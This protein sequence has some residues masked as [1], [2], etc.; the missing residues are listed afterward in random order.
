MTITHAQAANGPESRSFRRIGHWMLILFL[1]KI[2][3]PSTQAQGMT[4]GWSDHDVVAGV[5]WAKSVPV[6]P[7]QTEAFRK[8]IDYWSETNLGLGSGNPAPS[9]SL[10]PILDSAEILQIFRAPDDIRDAASYLGSPAELNLLLTDITQLGVLPESWR[11]QHLFPE[12]RREF[13]VR[14]A[15]LQN[16]P[17]PQVNWLLFAGLSAFLVSRYSCRRD[18]PF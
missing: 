13:A 5:D 14:F 10:L 4:D 2:G 16:V 15:T 6:G 18:R 3:L 8:L 17:E 11:E 1:V 7:E 9:I 12:L